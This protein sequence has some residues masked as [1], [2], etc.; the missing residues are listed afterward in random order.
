MLRK[1]LSEF[2]WFSLF[3]LFAGIGIVQL[4]P[5]KSASPNSKLIESEVREQNFMLG[6]AAV[7]A[8]CVM[9]GF[10]SVYFEKLLKHTS[11][12]IYLRNVQLGLIGIIFGLF[13]AL[14]NDGKQVSFQFSMCSV[15]RLYCVYS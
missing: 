15:Y 7:L 4:Q 12:S 13:A 3:L 1:Q 6:I 9:S 10:A 11:P 5:Q 8:A 14:Y 2:Q